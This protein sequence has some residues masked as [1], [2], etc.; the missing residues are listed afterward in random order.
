MF[1]ESFISSNSYFIPDENERMNVLLQIRKNS[2]YPSQEIISEPE[3]FNLFIKNHQMH[4]KEYPEFVKNFK[5]KQK[6]ENESKES[7]S[8]T[9]QNQ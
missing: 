1:L 5:Q 9:T 8:N 6:K 3:H 2:L 4:Q 7:A